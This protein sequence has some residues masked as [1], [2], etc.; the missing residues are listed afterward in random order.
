MFIGSKIAERERERG[1]ESYFDRK[2]SF[3]QVLPS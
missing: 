2:N 1:V 3:L